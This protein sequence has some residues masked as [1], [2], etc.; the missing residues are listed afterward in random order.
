[1]KRSNRNIFL[2]ILPLFL[3]TAGS[4]AVV[5]DGIAKAESVPAAKQSSATTAQRVG[6]SSQTELGKN[7]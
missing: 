3:F 1:M 5:A 7:G 6:L 4:A 2:W